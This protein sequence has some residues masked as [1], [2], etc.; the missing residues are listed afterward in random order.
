[1]VFIGRLD[2]LLVV[3]WR[4]TISLPV[5]YQISGTEGGTVTIVMSV[6]RCVRMREAVYKLINGI[7]GCFRLHGNILS[8]R[9]RT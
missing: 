6:L 4:C 5:A 3:V 8:Y 9:W 2:I 7:P 1:M